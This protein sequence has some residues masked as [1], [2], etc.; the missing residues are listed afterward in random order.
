MEAQQGKSSI[1][2]F[3]CVVKLWVLWFERLDA[4]ENSRP[5]SLREAFREKD[6]YDLLLK[7]SWRKS[8]P[9]WSWPQMMIY[10]Y[11]ADKV[12]AYVISMEFSAVNRRHP[13]RETPLWPGTW[14]D[15]CFRSRASFSRENKNEESRVLVLGPYFSR[16]VSAVVMHKVYQLSFACSQT[17]YYGI[18]LFYH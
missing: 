8:V 14:K 6:V 1:K 10:A 11:F 12:H 5:S 18:L 13:S 2:Y 9:H 3:A 17:A 15:G 4:C 16:L 7:I